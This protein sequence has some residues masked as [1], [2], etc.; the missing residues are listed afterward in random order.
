MQRRL[1]HADAHRGVGEPVDQ[2]E[3]AEVVA[4]G[5][6]LEGHGRLQLQLHVAKVIEA[7]RL[8]PLGLAGVHVDAV[9]DAL[10]LPRDGVGL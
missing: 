5:V 9:A 6:R 7:Q 1:D 10:K 3:A 2:D 8:R 4:F